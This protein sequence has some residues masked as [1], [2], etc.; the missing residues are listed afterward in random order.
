M[1]DDPLPYI[2]DVTPFYDDDFQVLNE[3][4]VRAR[5]TWAAGTAVPRLRRNPL[6]TDR[7]M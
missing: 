6:I 1:V 5:P 3:I 7:R 2:D 4:R